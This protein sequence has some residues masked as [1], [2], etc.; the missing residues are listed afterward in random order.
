MSAATVSGP[1]VRDDQYVEDDEAR[2]QQQP[3]TREESERR[4]RAE[5]S[6]RPRSF[7]EWVSLGISI[8][9]VAGVVGLV[10]YQHVTRRTE[11]AVIEV[12]AQL[13]KVRRAGG[14]YYVPLEITNSG[15]VTAEEV[16]VEVELVPTRGERE[17]A[18]LTVRFLAG[19]DTHHA[20]AVFKSDPTQGTLTA[21]ARSLVEP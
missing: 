17:R 14:T 9:I 13:D 19:G 11:P 8:L 20:T 3:E 12:Q 16:V 7:A 15:G 21:T 4:G 1:G 2:A 6:D 5:R 10:L 18:E